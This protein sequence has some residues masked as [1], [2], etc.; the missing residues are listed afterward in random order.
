MR[1][2]TE[3]LLA[4]DLAVWRKKG[5]FLTLL[6]LSAFQFYNVYVSSGPKLLPGLWSFRH[7]LGMAAL[8]SIAQISLGFYLLNNKIPNYVIYSVLITA[9]FSQLMFGLAVILVSNA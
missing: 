1:K 4:T 6:F 7:F 9:L 2:I 8:Q 3:E 5:V